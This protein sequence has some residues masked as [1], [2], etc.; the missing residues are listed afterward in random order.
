MNE[1]KKSQNIPR[2]PSGQRTLTLSGT[3]LASE[4]GKE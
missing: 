4:E 1:L 2:Q 3:R